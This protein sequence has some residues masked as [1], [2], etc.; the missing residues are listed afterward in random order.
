MIRVDPPGPSEVF[1]DI[2][3]KCIVCARYYPEVRMVEYEGSWYCNV[4]F[5]FRYRKKLQDEAWIEVYDDPQ[6]RT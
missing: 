4:C 3:H 1:D 6:E 5:D 2:W